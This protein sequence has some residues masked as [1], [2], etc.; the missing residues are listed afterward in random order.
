MRLRVSA[1]I[2]RTLRYIPERMKFAPVTRAKRNP[3]HAAAMSNAGVP[4]MFSS[5]PM[6]Q[7]VDGKTISGVMVATMISSMSL[8]SSP[9]ATMARRLGAERRGRLPR[10][11]DPPLADARPLHDPLVAG[12][13]HFR[14]VVVGQAALG[15]A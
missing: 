7:A 2:T 11:G 14:Q 6:K 10:P 13:D 5:A 8:G 3:L 9:A 12:L 4:G 15:K 1:P